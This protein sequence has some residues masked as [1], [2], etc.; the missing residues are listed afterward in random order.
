M[1]PQAATGDDEYLIRFLITVVVQ[2]TDH[3]AEAYCHPVDA[4]D[5]KRQKAGARWLR[6]SLS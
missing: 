1:V 2:R 6:L 3:G 5:S 4:R